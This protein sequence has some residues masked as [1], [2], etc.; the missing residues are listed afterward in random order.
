VLKKG[1]RQSK[2]VED[3]RPD[4]RLGG[5]N[6]SDFLRNL[7]M[8]RSRG[9]GQTKQVKSNFPLVPDEVNQRWPLSIDKLPPVSPVASFSLEDMIN[10]PGQPGFNDDPLMYAP[11][12]IT[13]A[14]QP[15]SQQWLRNTAPDLS[16]ADT[17]LPSSYGQSQHS[18]ALD[19]I[20]R[21][22]ALLEQLFR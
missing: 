14:E 3:V 22:P 6:A 10:A 1:T 8:M 11:K 17:F 16:T 15:S 12:Y 5:F 20:R 13:P 9:E 18:T 2:R 7:E 21:N 4:R 19:L